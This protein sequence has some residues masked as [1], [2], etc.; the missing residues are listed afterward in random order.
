MPN[1]YIQ[2]L[3]KKHNISTN[4]LESLWDKAKKQAK[5]QDRKDDYAYIMG[6][7]KNMI[8][9][10]YGIKENINVKKING[11]WKI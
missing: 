4:S 10:K 6:I 3:S 2:S 7:F 1:N 11:V 8:K 5:K 9:G